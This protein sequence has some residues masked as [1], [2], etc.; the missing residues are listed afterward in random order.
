[1]PAGLI[2]ALIT[3]GPAVVKVIQAT[4]E[5]ALQLKKIFSASGAN[6]SIELISIQDGAIK[7]AN[8]TLAAIAAWK[9]ANGITD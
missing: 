6:F 5:A 4:I 9:A 8:D 2:I 3:Q 7:D 1:M